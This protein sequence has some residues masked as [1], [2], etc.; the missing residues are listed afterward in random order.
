MNPFT[1]YSQNDKTV[2]LENIGVVARVRDG[3]GKRGGERDQN[4]QTAGGRSLW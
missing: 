2:E 3:V 4:G 1:L